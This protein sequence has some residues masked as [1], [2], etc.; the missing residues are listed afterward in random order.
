M[1]AIFSL[2]GLW[3]DD[4]FWYYLASSDRFPWWEFKSRLLYPFIQY[5]LAKT[6]VSLSPEVPRAIHIFLFMIP[7]SL[8]FYY[9]YHRIF[10]LERGLA[11]CA[12][13]IP[14]VLPNQMGIPAGIN[15]SYVLWGF[16]PTMLG[17]VCGI[18]FIQSGNKGRAWGILALLLFFT[19][20][21]SSSQA[22]F[23]GPPIALLFLFF[24]KK[25]KRRSLILFSGIFFIMLCKIIHFV[26]IPRVGVNPMPFSLETFLD[27]LKIFL[28]Q[29]FPLPLNHVSSFYIALFFIFTVILATVFRNRSGLKIPNHFAWVPEKLYPIFFLGFVTLWITTTMGPFL[30][31]SPDFRVYDYS[32]TANFGMAVFPVLAAYF[33][34]SGKS[35]F[36][37][38]TCYAVLACFILLA[39][40]YK[41]HYL[42]S[43]YANHNSS[44]KFLRESLKDIDFPP[45][46]QVVV[47]SLFVHHGGILA[48]NSGYL[49]YALNR[50]DIIGLIGKEYVW[51]DPFRKYSGW[52]N[53]MEGLS[54][55][56]PLYLFRRDGDIPVQLKYF[57]RVKSTANREPENRYNWELHELNSETGAAALIQAGNGIQRYKK[58][59]FRMNINAKAIAW[60]A[61]Y[62]NVTFLKP[63]QARLKKIRSDNL[64]DTPIKFGDLYLLKSCLIEEDTNNARI[65]VNLIFKVLKQHTL[66]GRQPEPPAIPMTEYGLYKNNRLIFKSH[67]RWDMTQ[68]LHANDHILHKMIF[69]KYKL[70]KSDEISIQ[71]V[72]ANTYPWKKLPVKQKSGKLIKTGEMRVPVSMILERQ[73]KRR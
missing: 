2:D 72:N 45:G 38:Y 6:M 36:W 3:H 16:L 14:H 22:F 53:R 35:K 27:R 46:A 39:G 20:N 32:Y 26:L 64:I 47:F 31:V 25:N 29:S 21:I 68:Y 23:M 70:R 65:T 44:T 9:L 66:A 18:R 7:L 56:K 8:C 30:T 11:C 43:K 63:S 41:Y 15:T 54:R 60:G 12:V 28:P 58:Y 50:N 73:K 40:I 34:L 69:P 1:V 55:K 19:A 48:A 59:L 67:S 4:S 10:G 49:R 61:F 57:L 71:I 5:L 17:V 13:I 42:S 33:I 37:K 62:P 51:Y 24:L 52:F